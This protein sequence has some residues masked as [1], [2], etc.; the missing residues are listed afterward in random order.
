MGRF[1]PGF[2]KDGNPVARSGYIVTCSRNA[3]CY[4]RCP[5]HPLTGDSYTCQKR[6][7]LYDVA[8]TGDDGEIDLVDL[9]SGSG[10]GFDPDSYEQAVTGETGICVDADSSLNQGCSEQTLASVVDAAVGCFDGQVSYFLCGLEINVKNGDPSTAAIE[11]NFFYPR[12]LVAA[13]E[14]SDGD[15][16]ATPEIRCSD[17]IDCVNVRLI[18]S[19]LLLAHFLSAVVL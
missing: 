10:S 16:V 19:Q 17:P 15:G 2:G 5:A 1:T 6:Y 11:G 14:D 18:C 8:V 7:N 13:G 12:V 4:N 9:Q 3:D